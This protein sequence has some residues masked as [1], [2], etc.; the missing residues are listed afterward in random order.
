MD[1]RGWRGDDDDDDDDERESN[2]QH[3]MLPPPSKRTRL[4][5]ITPPHTSGLQTTHYP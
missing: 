4:N 3:R 5:M 2:D 1:S